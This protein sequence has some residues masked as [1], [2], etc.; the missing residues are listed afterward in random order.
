MIDSFQ[1][2]ASRLWLLK[3]IAV[4]MGVLFFVLVVVITIFSTSQDDVKYLIPG[5]IGILWSLSAYGFTSTFQFVPEKAK[6]SDGFFHRLK[7]NIHRSW[8]WLIA[9]IFAGT[10]IATILSSI[11][12]ISIWI[13]N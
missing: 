10:T 8:Y 6:S 2:F 13:N 4:G 7:R 11:R 3:I 9:I 5:V 12:L 1:K